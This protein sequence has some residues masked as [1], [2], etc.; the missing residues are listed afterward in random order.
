MEEGRKREADAHFHVMQKV[1]RSE[2]KCLELQK[3][4][5]TCYETTQ[6]R[7]EKDYDHDLFTSFLLVDEERNRLSCFKMV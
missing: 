1:V 5:F 3:H 4:V 2:V 7:S 6:R